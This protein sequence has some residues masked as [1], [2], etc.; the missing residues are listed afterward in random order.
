[1]YCI[2]IIRVHEN[3]NKCI[4]LYWLIDCHKKNSNR[5][6]IKH[7]FLFSCIDIIVLNYMC[8]TKKEK[9]YAGTK[10]YYRFLKKITSLG[11][12]VNFYCSIETCFKL[13]FHLTKKES[14]LLKTSNLFRFFN[15]IDFHFHRKKKLCFELFRLM[16]WPVFKI[17]N[18][19]ISY[20]NCWLF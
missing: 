12:W 9:L 1:M 14:K 19:L 5:Y 17:S 13:R 8:E 10:N 20:F 2:I 16:M 11:I 7:A 4:E 6:N 3:K 18:E 15:Q